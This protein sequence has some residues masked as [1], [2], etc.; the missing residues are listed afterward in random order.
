LRVL[1][2]LGSLTDSWDELIVHMLENKVDARTLRA[3]EEEIETNE[4]PKLVDML[5]FLKRRCQT[6][7][8]IESRAVEKI[9]RSKDGEQRDKGSGMTGTKP[10]SFN[11]SETSKKTTLTTSLDSG[12]CFFCNG[13][14]FIYFCEKF[15]ALTIP[16]RIKE[17]KRLRLCLNCL[18]NDHYVKTCKMGHCRECTGRHNTLCHIPHTEGVSPVDLVPPVDSTGSESHSET[19]IKPMA[20][21]VSVHHSSNGGQKRHILMATATVEASRRDGTTLLIRVLLDSASEANFITNHAHNKLGLRRDKI[22]EIVSS[23]NEIENKVHSSC[24]V[25]IK[26]KHSSFGINVQCLIVPKITKY[27]PS[28]EID[29]KKLQIP[30]NFNLADDEFF[31]PG[32]IDMLLGAEYFYDLIE[33]GK[34]ELGE[35][36]LVLQNTKL[37]WIVA[38]SMQP[39]TPKNQI[40]ISNSLSV[41]ICSLNSEESLNDNLEKF[42]KLEGYDNERQN[43][44][45]DEERCENLFEQTT[46]RSSD[47]RFI[48]RLPFCKEHRSIGDNRDVALRRL[49][50]LESKFMSDSMFHN[51]YVNFM[52]EY[53]NLGHMSIVNESIAESEPI[54]YLPHHGVVKEHSNTKLRVVFDASAKNSKGVSL[55]DALLVGP[56]LQ[57]DLINI[58]IRFRFRRVVITADLQKMY[59]QILVHSNDRN[60]QRI[61]WRFSLEEPVKEYQLNTVTYGQACAPYLSIRC[62]RQLAMEGSERYPLAAHALLNDTYVDDIITGADTIDDARN[63]RKQLDALLAEGKFKAHK[64]CSNLDEKIRKRFS[65]ININDM[66]KTLGLEWNHTLDEFRFT[67]QITSN[68]NTKREMLS[69]ISKLFDPLGLIGPVL[70]TAKILM[71]KLWEIKVNWDDRLPEE[72]LDKWKDFQTS[73]VDVNTLRVPRLI[74]GSSGR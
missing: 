73:L 71:Q 31:K 47:G 30:K 37:G 5:E 15:L 50:Q 14:H 68:V 22:S 7:E 66:V 59:R 55:N 27:L 61:L 34:I 49:K 25:Q 67:I 39:T 20:N 18:K 21:S 48:V 11:K 54:V 56:T 63:L 26:S 65:N 41:M 29:Y 42:W 1:K 64:W 9:E 46:E 62:L 10:H 17:V 36:Q 69:A 4:N 6:I 16:D 32:A 74:V 12:K 8:R 72:I 51:R 40:C 53:V 3:W 13:N 57:D 45:V 35:H 58:I 44:S 43:L 23:L 2:A 33:N 28:V 24:N 60:C 38:G 70:T 52:R 19:S